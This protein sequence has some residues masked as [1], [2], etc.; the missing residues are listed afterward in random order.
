SALLSAHPSAPRVLVDVLRSED[1][2]ARALAVDGIGRK[3]GVHAR[4]DLIPM[5]A[6]PDP[7][8]RRAAIAAVAPF[9][10]EDELARIAAMARE[11]RDGPVR[12]RALRALASRSAEGRIELA[13]AAL[14]DPYA[15]ARRAAVELLARG[16]SAE[17]SAALAEVVAGDDLELALAAAAARLR[18]ERGGEA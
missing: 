17:A 1:P 15:G 18:A 9:A 16:G 13:R 10:E 12:A 7:G 5:L 3:A 11:D 4:G 8:V 14:R 2:R 6:D